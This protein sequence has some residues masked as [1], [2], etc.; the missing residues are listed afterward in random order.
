[1]YSVNSTEAQASDFFNDIN[2]AQELQRQGQKIEKSIIQRALVPL[3][4]MLADLRSP[5]DVVADLHEQAVRQLGGD[6]SRL[7]VGHYLLMESDARA[8]PAI[9]VARMNRPVRLTD[10]RVCGLVRRFWAGRATALEVDTAMSAA[11]WVAK[12][13]QEAAARRLLALERLT[14]ATL[15]FPSGVFNDN[16]TADAA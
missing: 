8:W 10:R 13:A 9:D 14:N 1:M 2:T 6:F 4:K 12:L 7:P 15:S 5:V 11:F 16:S 3:E